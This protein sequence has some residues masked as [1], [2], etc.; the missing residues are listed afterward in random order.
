MAVVCWMAMPLW[1]AMTP[2][3]GEGGSTPLDDDGLLCP[4]RAQGWAS[5]PGGRCRA[6]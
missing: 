6:R 1:M 3:D 2:A 5:A 4:S